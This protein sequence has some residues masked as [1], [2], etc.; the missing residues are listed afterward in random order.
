MPSKKKVLISWFSPRGDTTEVS[1]TNRRIPYENG[2]NYS[3]R[4]FLR[5]QDPTNYDE[6]YLLTTSSPEDD[7]FKNF[8]KEFRRNFSNKHSIIKPRYLTFETANDFNNYNIV[9]GKVKDFLSLLEHDDIYVLFSAG[10]G[11]M[12]VTWVT[13]KLEL[14]NHQITLWQLLEAQH[15]KEKKPHIETMELQPTAVPINAFYH[16]QQERQ[17]PDASEPSSEGI[18]IPASI[19]PEYDKAELLAKEDVRILIRGASGTGKENLAKHIQEH[20]RRKGK[21]FITINCSAYVSDNLLRSELFG[22]K[23]GAFTGADDDKKGIFEEAHGGTVFLDE[24]GD[25]SPAMQVMLLRF[26]QEGEIQPVGSTETKKVDVRI[27][28]ASHHDLVQRF[29]KGKFREDLYFR[30][31]EFE[32]ELPSLQ[33]WTRTEKRKLI[34]HLLITQQKKLYEPSRLTTADFEEK[35]LKHLLNYSYPGNIRQMESIVTQ[36]CIMC[37]KRVRYEDLPLRLVEIAEIHQ[38]QKNSLPETR[39]VK[40]LRILKEH[41]YRLG[42]SAKAY[43]TALN[44]FKKHAREEGLEEHISRSKT[45]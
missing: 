27:I 38:N 14:K 16:Q 3:F 11:V 13:L 29:A 19:Q 40:I 37:P 1:G 12:Q 42:D 45:R 7:N 2:V 35:A 36:L 23:K 20:S 10:N 5:E 22:H 33:Q 26:L 17:K 28:A 6:H 39:R 8:L 31:A 21:K 15:T 41:N 43:K 34:D 30:L 18:Y 32:L 44:T 4:K 9:K 25:I 24:I